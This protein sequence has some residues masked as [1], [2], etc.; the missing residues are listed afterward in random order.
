MVAMHPQEVGEANATLSFISP[1]HKS[2]AYGFVLSIVRVGP[3]AR[4]LG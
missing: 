3:K 2:L 1:F 4:L